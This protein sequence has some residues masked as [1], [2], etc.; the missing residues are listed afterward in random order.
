M[1][2]NPAF[3]EKNYCLANRLNHSSKNTNYIS[4]GD[5]DHWVVG[6]NEARE[7]GLVW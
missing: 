2:E 1:A 5:G 3:K 4:T 7:E 6:V